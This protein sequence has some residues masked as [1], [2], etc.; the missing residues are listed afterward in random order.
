MLWA[1]L[2]VVSG[3]VAHR[4]KIKDPMANRLVNLA[5]GTVLVGDSGRW[6]HGLKNWVHHSLRCTNTYV[7]SAD[8]AERAG[9]IAEIQRAVAS[10]NPVRKKHSASG[11]DDLLEMNGEALESIEAL[12]NLNTEDAIATDRQKAVHMFHM[13][14]RLDYFF[15]GNGRGSQ[16]AYQHFFTGLSGDTIEISH[17]NELIRLHNTL[18]S[19]YSAATITELRNAF[20]D[21]NRQLQLLARLN[22][23]YVPRENQRIAGVF[24]EAA[25]MDVESKL[26]TLNAQDFGNTILLLDKEATQYFRAYRSLVGPM[27]MAS[28]MRAYQAM[29]GEHM[30]R[31]SALLA[32]LRDP[33]TSVVTLDDMRLADWCLTGAEDGLAAVYLALTMGEAGQAFGVLIEAIQAYKQANTPFTNREAGSWLVTS[34]IR[35]DKI[36]KI[37]D[38][39]YENALLKTDEQGNLQTILTQTEMKLQIA[40]KRVG[41]IEKLV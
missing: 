19:F 14:N 20:P 35:P 21:I 32:A 41:L 7:S 12:A 4:I 5:T 30:L 23:I 29:R 34:G 15:A 9:F 1:Y 26:A 40:M 10:I 2:S 18:T 6:V 31:T 24:N 3:S 39:L 25:A 36:Q 17:K 13:P 28:Q 8:A 37:L 33:H 38:Q 27:A 16:D 22:V 11:A